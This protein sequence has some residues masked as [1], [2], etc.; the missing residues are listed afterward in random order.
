[1]KILPPSGRKDEF[2]TILIGSGLLATLIGVFVAA[3]VPNY[4]VFAILF[5][6]LT[7]VGVAVLHAS[8]G[9]A[10]STIGSMWSKGVVWRILV[11]VGAILVALLLAIAACTFLLGWL[12]K[13]ITTGGVRNRDLYLPRAR[14]R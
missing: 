9:R 11:I 14:R 2:T 6:V 12:V 4:R 5:I 8:K 1:M 10:D 13:S 7:W 3:A